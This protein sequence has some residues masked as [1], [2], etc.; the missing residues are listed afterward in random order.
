[1]ARQSRPRQPAGR[2]C[3]NLQPPQTACPL[4]H[5]AGAAVV[6]GFLYVFGT[7]L[8]GFLLIQQ[9][10]ASA[11]WWWVA[12]RAACPPA[13]LGPCRVNPT[14]RASLYHCALKNW[15]C[16]KLAVFALLPGCL[17]AGAR[18]PSPLSSLIIPAPA[19]LPQGHLPGAGARLGAVPQPVRDQAR[20]ACVP[21]RLGLPRATAWLQHCAD[22]ALPLLGCQHDFAPAPLAAACASV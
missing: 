9:F 18:P 6:V 5:I 8:V 2:R 4:A 10:V 1:M 21:F 19:P 3:S 13:V 17:P 22:R 20:R 15:R 7:G 12:P 14:S 16:L 11:Y